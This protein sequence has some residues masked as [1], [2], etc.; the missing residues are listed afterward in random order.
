MNF[1]KLRIT[2][3]KSFVEPT[4]V[5]IEPG[6]TG[7]VGPN[8][9][10]KS[11][12]VEALRWVMGETSA[13]QLRGSGMDDVIF[14]GTTDRPARNIAE[15]VL[16]LDN[17]QRNAPG[18]F[19][20]SDEIEVSRRIE[21]GA[22]S[23]YR[24]NGREVRARD[25]Q[26]LFAD[27]T[28]GAH[29]PAIVSQGRVGA[30]IGAKPTERR[31]LLEEAAGIIGLHSR[32]HEAELRLHGAETN[33]ERLEDVVAALQAQYDGLRRQARQ[34]VRYRKMSEELRQ[35]EAI[36]LYQRWTEASTSRDA[37]RTALQATESNVAEQTRAASEASRVQVEAA[38]AVPGRRDAE[39]AAAAE[40]QRLT[41]ARRELDAEE[42]RLQESLEE[43]DRQ[44]AQIAT[45]F[46]RETALAADAKAALARLEREAVEVAAGGGNEA[47][48][49]AAAESAMKEA[50]EAL[51]TGER[52]LEG[53]TEQ[54]ATAEARKERLDQQLAELTLRIERLQVRA[55]E[56]E[57]ERAEAAKELPEEE[58]VAAAAETL[59][60]AEAA[61]TKARSD[62][63]STE[64]ARSLSEKAEAEAR[65]NAQEAESHRAKLHAEAQA[66]ADVLDTGATDLFPPLIDALMV[67][68][69]YETALGA[70]LGEDLTAPLDTA[71]D[72]HWATLPPLGPPPDPPAGASPFER[73]V[74]GPEAI[75][76]RLQ[77]I[78]VVEDSAAGD[79]I[80]RALKPGQRVVSKD[81]ALWRWDGY[82]VRAGTQTA[83]AKRLHQRNRL[84]E[85]EDQITD[86]T[87]ARDAA[88]ERL[89][90]I[91]VTVERAVATEK[92]ARAA[93][94]KA[95][96]ALIAARDSHGELSHTLA[97]TRSRVKGLTESAE[98][99]RTDLAEAE[100]EHERVILALANHED[101]ERA[102]RRI[103]ALRVEV[104]ELRR[105][106]AD[107]HG[108]FES[109]QRQA[110][111]QRRRLAAIE[112]E[113]SSWTQRAE[114][115]EHR[116]AHLRERQESVDERK[117][118]LQSRPA[119]IEE[120]RNSLLNLIEQAEATRRGAADRLAESETALADADKALRAAEAALA[121]AREARIRAEAQADHADN[122]CRV[123]AE[124]VSERLNCAPH[125]ILRV[126]R[127]E[128]GDDLP[129]RAETEQKIEELTRRRD[130][131]GPVNLPAESELTELEQKIDTMK[132]EREDLLAAI[133]RLRQGISSLNREGR[134]RLLAAFER[135]NTHFQDLFVRLFGGGRAH[136]T[137]TESDD[138]LAA[139]L[140][141]MAS[142]PGKKLQV[143]SL[144]SGGEQALTAV[145][146][147]F[148]VFLTNPAP[149]CILDEVDAPLD[150]ANVDRF[151]TLL[152]HIAHSGQTRFLCVTHHRMT[153]ARMDRLFGVTMGERGVSQLV[154]V[155]LGQAEQLRKTA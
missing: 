109:L 36:L 53:L 11:N 50:R 138:P 26:L 69:G 30:I 117:Q 12:I 135:V 82:T 145:A 94:D 28:V 52:A 80:A 83:A 153:M 128:S 54:A 18:G 29:S 68:P 143:M 139:G 102:R 104:G 37:A 76:R 23:T 92:I 32:R 140:E 2:G 95:Y 60:A 123:V 24:I 73:F 146:L 90:E 72:V 21:R 154:S 107:R 59:E 66:L 115:T 42:S 149:I 118:S 55:E 40:L 121:E 126:A 34:A 114:G 87:K 70:A 148:A 13:K 81:G 103:E 49:T 4:E 100:E 35:Y 3:F 47:A 105:I 19:N 56:T 31:M 137:L 7:V 14:N 43:T 132:T 127:I 133:A 120:Q 112:E 101:P 27:L 86:A 141:I 75:Q 134:E 48:A 10:G 44:L 8:G 61:L 41:L 51:E 129:P 15:V 33:L 85:L 108:A 62:L 144:L 151:C 98:Q 89:D 122:E 131:M 88:S 96:N 91:Q 58:T 99:L 25:V 65:K 16:T 57:A 113:K 142:P 150:D 39:V 1:S 46:E 9:C 79:E 84:A 64:A 38:E 20:E 67:E 130:A 71:A 125:E 74:R 116:L 111:D 97:N 5:Y 78:S 152:D 17:S 155:D 63:E 93:V 45:D 110:E 106:A 136:L 124:R 147:L 119:E 77:F 22:G 6:I